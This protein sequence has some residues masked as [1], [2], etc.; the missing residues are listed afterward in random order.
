MGR[1]RLNASILV[2]LSSQFISSGVRGGEGSCANWVNRTPLLPNS[3]PWNQPVAAFD[4]ARSRTVMFLTDYEGAASTWEWDGTTWILRT[5]SGPSGRGDTA[6]VYDS[7]RGV[8]VLHGGSAGSGYLNDT[9]EWDGNSWSLKSTTGPLSRTQYCVAYDSTRHRT[10]L[11]GSFGTNFQPQTWE[12]DGLTWMLVGTTGPSGQDAAMAYDSDRNKTVLFGSGNNASFTWTWDGSSWNLVSTTGPDAPLDGARMIYDSNEHVAVL[13]GGF[14]N[15]Q[16]G[17]DSRK[18]WK[19]DGTQWNL[20]STDGPSPRNTFAFAFDSH[21]GKSVMFG[22][23][24]RK[25]AA[26]YGDT[27]EYDGATWAK[28]NDGRPSRRG[29]HTM[30]FDSA[31]NRTVLFGGSPEENGALAFE[32]TWEWD[33]AVWR[34]FIGPGPLGRIVSGMAFDSVRNE[35]LMF[36]GAAS[37]F[38]YPPNYVNDTWGWDG[39]SWTL[40]ANSGPSP[41]ANHALAFDSWRGVSV[42]YGG[43]DQSG[44]P[45]D[46]WEW[47]GT[48]WS[49]R[50][51]NG[52]TAQANRSMSFN[53]DS[54]NCVLFGGTPDYISYL[55]ETW[56]WNGTTWVQKF[57][58]VHPMGLYRQASAYDS[59]RHV[60]VM[61]GGGQGETYNNETWEW[62]G[63]NWTQRPAAGIPAL[64]SIRLAYD[65]HRHKLVLFGGFDNFGGVS[66]QI[67]ELEYGGVGPNVVMQSG[68]PAVCR[69]SAVSFQVSASGAGVLTYQW[70]KNGVSLNDGAGLAGTHSG[71]LTLVSTAEADTAAYSCLVRDDCGV[72]ES[73]SGSL[74]VYA[75]GSADGNGDGVVD[76][77]DVQV[78]VDV[79]TGFAPVSAA[80]CA[81][82]LTGEGI[83]NVDDLG[84]FVG[85][86]L[87]E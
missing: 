10:V 74:T 40:R 9:W 18:T 72:T 28:R 19:W 54:G 2:F 53:A 17:Q 42:M 36:G 45:G 86:L 85:R 44:F 3:E 64:G 61:F 47:D 4:S 56:L 57:P 71:T 23:V 51:Q 60:T 77:R 67:W 80:M 5:T 25:R 8:C 32:D 59:D 55:D 33:G 35:T 11:V 16:G 13:F 20:A 49:M 22:G 38:P 75:G 84:L 30:A 70:R 6:M 81:Y 82:D 27:W 68:S 76:G 87:G 83:V 1:I 21:R 52:P 37:Q 24:A 79:L 65:S 46:T 69:G 50:P 58:V 73:D 31:R 14:W 26:G 15:Y 48:Q 12:W 29:F 7:F 39:N 78:L 43:T 41:R 62:D 34:T 66:D 63:E